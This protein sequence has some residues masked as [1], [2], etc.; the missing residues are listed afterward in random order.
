MAAKRSVELLLDEIN[1]LNANAFTLSDL[2]FGVPARVNQYERNTKIK[3]T[4]TPNSKYIGSQEVW[5]NRLDLTKVFASAQIETIELKGYDVQS[6]LDLLKELNHTYSLNLDDKDIVEEALDF[7]HFPQT[8]ILR[9]HGD[10]MAFEGE[11]KV[12]VIEGIL[13][14]DEVIVV[15]VLSGLYYLNDLDAMITND[16][17][18][19]FTPVT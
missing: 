19:G 13:D 10:S 7:T 6:T 1:R 4:A 9:T 18:N 8:V 3:V 2:D 14:L 16:A 17:M 11:L 12:T 15:Q 5:Y